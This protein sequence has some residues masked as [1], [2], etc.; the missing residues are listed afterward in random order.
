MKNIKYIVILLILFIS[1]IYIKADI[2]DFN[3]KGT[4]VIELIES[5]DNTK[6]SDSEVVIYKLADAIELNNNLS[7]KYIDELNK[8]SANINS[9]QEEISKLNNCI[10]N[11]ELPTYKGITNSEG[12]VI[13]NEL[14][15]GLYLITETKTN[16]KYSLFEPFILMLPLQDNNNWVYSVLSN[17]KTDIIKLIDLTVKKEWNN[18]TSNKLPK[19]VTIELLKDEELID[20]VVLNQD[21]DWTHI[22]KDIEKS[23]NYKVREINIPTG[24][25][26]TYSNYDYTFIITN[27]NTLIKTGNNPIIIV[28]SLLLGIALIIIGILHNRKV[29][30][31]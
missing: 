5:T 1:P 14:D 16:E 30:H 20:T 8:C 17:P 13:F 28:I 12:I 3:K 27:T 19:S 24:Y 6:V 10:K 29:N 23:D 9:L 15:L 11:K 18:S 22:W 2:V 25:T 7:F 31:E 21:N 26:P 4:I